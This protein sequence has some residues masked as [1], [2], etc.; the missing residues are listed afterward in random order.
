MI[1]VLVSLLVSLSFFVC[2]HTIGRFFFLFLSD[3][4]PFFLFVTLLFFTVLVF[5]CSTFPN[6]TLYQRRLTWTKVD[7]D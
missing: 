4:S 5:C 2:I 1:V 7:L 6:C 3:V